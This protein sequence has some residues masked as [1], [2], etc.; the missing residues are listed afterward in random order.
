MRREMKT[1]AFSFEWPMRLTLNTQESSLQ[2]VF[3]IAIFESRTACAEAAAR[4]VYVS[5]SATF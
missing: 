1:D 5:L 2:R 3:S 4:E